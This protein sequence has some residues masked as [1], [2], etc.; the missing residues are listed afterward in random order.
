MEGQKNVP[1]ILRIGKEYFTRMANNTGASYENVITIKGSGNDYSVSIDTNGLGYKNATTLCGIRPAFYLK[2]N[3][4]VQSSE[5]NLN[6]PFY[7]S[8]QEAKCFIGFLFNTRDLTEE[9]IKNGNIYAFLTGQLSGE[10][11]I[12][13]GFSFIDQMDAQLS[14]TISKYEYGSAKGKEWLLNYLSTK[15]ENM[16]SD[17]LGDILESGIDYLL[18]EY[19]KNGGP[20]VNGQYDYMLDFK[21]GKIVFDLINIADQVDEYKQMMLAMVGS[22]LYAGGENRRIMYQYFADTKSNMVYK[23]DYPST[24]HFHYE[25]V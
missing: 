10:N 17:I 23:Y 22:C 2:S 13:A 5:Y 7:L 14:R 9:Q 19:E 6:M 3:N 4:N 1:N 18:D 11:E 8:E 16:A 12:N 20:L 15:A 21:M 25:S 24:F